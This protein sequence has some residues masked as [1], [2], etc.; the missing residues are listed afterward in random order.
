[1]GTVPILPSDQPAQ[2]VELS[3]DPGALVGS[4][5]LTFEVE[6]AY[7]YFNPNQPDLVGA[8]STMHVRTSVKRQ[9]CRLG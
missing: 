3:G 1:M 6:Q 4:M 7:L 5:W 2:V 8:K 9:R